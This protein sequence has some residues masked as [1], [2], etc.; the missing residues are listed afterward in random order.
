MRETRA[1]TQ[2]AYVNR[3]AYI[4]HIRETK[5]LKFFKIQCIRVAFAH[6]VSAKTIRFA[7]SA[8]TGFMYVVSFNSI[9]ILTYQYHMH[10]LLVF[11]QEKIKPWPTKHNLLSIAIKTQAMHNQ[12]DLLDCDKQL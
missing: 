3:V 2:I 8:N 6:R 11:G 9:T 12:P 7:Y 5:S 4:L 1:R 10:L